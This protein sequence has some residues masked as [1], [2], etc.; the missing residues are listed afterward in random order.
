[1]PL[2]RIRPVANGLRTDHPIPDLPFVDDTHIP[3]DEPVAIEAIGRKHGTDTWGRQDRCQDGG[4]VAFT[5]DPKRHDLAW[6]VRWHPDNGRSVVLYRD[7]DVAGAHMSYWGPA[8]LFRAGDYWWD[9]THWYRPA[10]VFD[11]ASE[12]YIRRDVPA[13]MA[14]TAA[15]LLRTGGDHRRATILTVE[16]VDLD[17]PPQ[18]QWLDDLALWAERRANDSPPL[19]GSIVRLTAPELTG[20]QLVGVVQMAEIA[21]VAPSTLRAYISRGESEVPLPQAT[22]SG[23]TVWSRAVAEEWAEAR[24]RSPEGVAAVVS[25]GQGGTT[26]SPPG[27]EDMSNW[28]ARLFFSRLWESL[29]YRKRWALRWRNED[30]VRDVAKDLSWDVGANLRR[31][32]PTTDLAATVKYAVLDELATGKDLDRSDDPILYGITPPV[33]RMLDWLIRHA[34]ETAMH[35]VGEIAGDAQRREDIPRE[36]T[37]RSLATALSLNGKLDTKERNEFLDRVLGPDARN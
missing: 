24:R 30:A 25:A 5:T 16:Q 36:V 31:I 32:V 27:V 28:F 4:W 3:V 1:M 14:V 22:V 21:S 37:K 19:S 33:S 17:A 15:D 18:S 9:G 13:A 20:D 26:P 2:H 29:K 23:R 34:P 7:D 12:D 35:A 11:V 10:Q 6:L 8:L